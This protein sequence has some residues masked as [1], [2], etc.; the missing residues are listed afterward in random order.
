MLYL[1]TFHVINLSFRSAALTGWSLYVIGRRLIWWMNGD[2]IRAR[3][4]DVPLVGLFS[5]RYIRHRIWSSLHNGGASHLWDSCMFCLTRRHIFMTVVFCSAVSTLLGN[6]VNPSQFSDM[7]CS[8]LR[9]SKFATKLDVFSSYW[10]LKFS[11]DGASIE[12]LSDVGTLRF[13]T[14]LISRQI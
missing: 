13:N 3:R 4:V 7:P 14:H 6:T 2:E 11:I 8:V 10:S 12:P 5:W 1:Y 9:C